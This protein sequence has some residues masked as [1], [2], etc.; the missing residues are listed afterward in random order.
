MTADCCISYLYIFHTI[1]DI[2]FVFLHYHILG[3]NCT[4]FLDFY[5]LNLN[6]RN[7]DRNLIRFDYYKENTLLKFMD[8]WIQKTFCA[9]VY[10][11]EPSF[12]NSCYCSWF[13]FCSF[14]QTITKAKFR[15]SF[16]STTSYFICFFI[17]F[18]F[19]YLFL[20]KKKSK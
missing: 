13:G 7:A 1:L 10:L 5:T 4:S 14:Y 17:I 8:V 20:Y 19:L 18:Y 15:D 11:L 2:S 16:F 9:M 3:N 12:T 6:I